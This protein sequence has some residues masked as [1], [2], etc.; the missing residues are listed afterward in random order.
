MSHPTEQT[1][2]TQHDLL[3]RLY[4]RYHKRSY[5]G[6]DPLGMV[7]GYSQPADRE[8]VGLVA[9]SLAY[10]NVK[11]IRAGIAGVLDVLGHEPIQWLKPR[12]PSAIRKRFGGWRYRVT[13]GEDLAGLLIGVR[14]QVADHG[15]LHAA[16]V[17]HLNSD[18]L[19][20]MARWSADIAHRAGRPLGHLLA[21]P[22]R[23]SA[24]KRLCLYLRWMVRRDAIDPG[25]WTGVCPS[26]LIAPV[27]VHLHRVAL[28]LGW[29]T[30][31]QLTLNTALDVTAALRKLRPDDPLR[32]D[33]ALTRPG[34]LKEAFE[35]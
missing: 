2:E 20:A 15:S 13:S 28:R 24:C 10:G 12:T 22:A 1:I 34:I 5:L 16:F 29:T 18:M 8:A 21:S 14:S 35:V 11:A 3:E 19:E 31:K 25:G 32:Y 26:Q 4:R 30:R 9:A 27:D 23:G 7:Y 6:S 17:H 33:F